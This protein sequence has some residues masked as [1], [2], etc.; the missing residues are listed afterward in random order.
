[1]IEAVETPERTGYTF[2]GW[3]KEIPTT[4]PAEN[5]TVTAKWKVKQ[6]TL[7]LVYGNGEADKTI[8]QDYNT[9][10]EAVGVPEREYYEFIGW[11]KAIP[12]T[13]PAGN[14]TVT[15]K[16]KS[17]FTV[18]GNT[19]TGLTE[20]GKANYT[21]LNIPSK[22][23]GMAITSIGDF[24]FEDC[25]SLKSVKIGNG[26]ISIGTMAFSCCN[27]LTNITIGSSVASIGDFAFV[28]SGL[29]NLI[30]PNNVTSIGTNLFGGCYNLTTVTIGDGVRSIEDFTF[31]GCSS[32]TSVTIGKNVTTIGN[33]AFSD[34]DSLT[35][36]TFEGTVAEWDAIGYDDW[37]GVP[38]TKVVCKDGNVSI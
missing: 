18:S 25:E 24:A 31:S 38:A 21:V 22:I 34:C 9:V 33:S 26:V 29:T 2:D 23:D 27:S 19:V 37:G 30:I 32:L 13:M 1:M 14:V 10:I 15:A 5:V 8:T 20:Y 11:D 12:T 6:Y 7:T 35:S 17:I 3:D 16:W 4:M 36:I 28:G